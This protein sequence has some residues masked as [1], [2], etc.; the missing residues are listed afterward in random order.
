MSDSLAQNAQDPKTS[1]EEQRQSLLMTALLDYAHGR[2]G[3]AITKYTQLLGHYQQSED[4]RMQAFLMNSLGDVFHRA[5]DLPGAL[6]WYECAVVPA[7][8]A[9]D[10]NILAS[11]TKNLG[12]VAYQ[13]GRY[14]E[15][16][17]Y[18]DGL[19][20]LT[21]VTLDPGTKIAALEWRGRSQEQQGKLQD[22]LGSLQAATQLAGTLAVTGVIDHLEAQCARL[23][24]KCGEFP[25]AAPV[26]RKSAGVQG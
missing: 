24:N 8:A 4:N 5:G 20:K 21:S 7:S 23:R 6:H 3:E 11:I 17:Q 12:E 15:A 1:P 26:F 10:P 14:S 19:D 13:Q 22:A 18:F 25:R 16:E 9:K 2:P